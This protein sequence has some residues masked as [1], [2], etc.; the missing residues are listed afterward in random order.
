[1]SKKLGEVEIG[2]T[3]QFLKNYHGET[4]PYIKQWVTGVIAGINWD[5]LTCV[6]EVPSK[7]YSLDTKKIISSGIRAFAM[8]L[9]QVRNIP[10]RDFPKAPDYASFGKNSP[11]R[12]GWKELKTK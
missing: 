6:V 1:M 8:P 12:N 3:V 11:C 10:E 7:K 9:D 2:S 5:T 4:Q